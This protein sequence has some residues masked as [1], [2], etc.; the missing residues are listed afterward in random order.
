MVVKGG[1]GSEVAGLRCGM[2]P[3]GWRMV[4]VNNLE[5][6]M[7]DGG[8]LPNSPFNFARPT[9]VLHVIRRELISSNQRRASPRSSGLGE[10][11][12]LR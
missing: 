7:T 8:N 1:Y 6:N 2:E 4:I 3:W 10:D 9:A 5:V 11:K 12:N